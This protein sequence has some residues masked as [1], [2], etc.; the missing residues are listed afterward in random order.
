MQAGNADVP[1]QPHPPESVSENDLKRRYLA[2][3]PPQQ[4]IDIC[5]NFELHVPQY[6]KHSIWP[7]D[8]KAAIAAL[9]PKPPSEPVPT[10]NEPPMASLV[11]TEPAPEKG[12]SEQQREPPKPPDPPQTTSEPPK[13][14]VQS[15]LSSRQANGSNSAPAQPA[16]HPSYPY[17]YPP[18]A[19]PHSPYYPPPPNYPYLPHPG[20]GYPPP[21]Y[22]P[23]Y[24]HPPSHPSH[25]HPQ[26]PTPAPSYAPG[27]IE[28]HVVTPDD[29]PSYEEMIVEA[30]VDSND[31]EG[32]MPKQLFAWMAS[33]YPIQSNF[34][35]SASQA[36]QKAFKRGRLEKSSDGKY[37]LSA[38]W[39][40]GNTS[41]RTTRRP[42][43][44]NISAVPATQPLSSPFTHAPRVHHHQSSN[45]PAPFTP[46][47]YQPQPAPPPQPQPQAQPTSSSSS[48]TTVPSNDE[49][50]EGSQAWEAAQTILKAL[51]F[52]SLLSMN[53][54]E[55]NAN[56]RIATVSHPTEDNSRAESA[57]RLNNSIQDASAPIM[58]GR[59][60]LQAQLALLATQ[61]AEIAQISVDDPLPPEPTCPATE[62]IESAPPSQRMVDVELAD[63]SDDDDMD[64]V[65]IL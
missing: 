65:T 53:A 12:S 47:P 5:L 11:R 49:I 4:I 60:S 54:E 46:A 38:T 2:L 10:S 43:T 20:Y 51:N 17:G 41:R 21:G 39:E 57:T 19:Y 45:S 44:Q 22:A 52:N 9:Q 50:G 8:L 18:S 16:P 58:A 40:G 27:Q 29:L 37:R 1:P 36:L 23:S 26:Q 15:G 61:L 56:A 13:N 33:H 30:L 25:L 55:A 48:T 63:D 34:R 64:E 31:P 62:A 3:L 59:A 6:V 35:P 24:P 7:I 32:W 14:D 42:Q 28:G